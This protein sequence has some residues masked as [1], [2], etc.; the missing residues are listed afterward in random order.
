MTGI[1]KIQ[2]KVNYIGGGIEPDR[3]IVPHATRLHHVDKYM[4]GYPVECVTETQRSI[5]ATPSLKG[6]AVTTKMVTNV[7]TLL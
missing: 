6:R 1:K 7:S 4:V 3:V 2:K 5:M